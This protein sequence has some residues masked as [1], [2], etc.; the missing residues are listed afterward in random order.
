MWREWLRETEKTMLLTIFFFLNK[1]KLSKNRI[2]LSKLL[3][4]QLFLGELPLWLP[5]YHRQRGLGFGWGIIHI[6]CCIS[7]HLCILHIIFSFFFPF[8][9]FF[10]F[11]LLPTHRD[12]IQSYH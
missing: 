1:T 3:L 10:T 2:Q 6:M 9:L 4:L 12:R 8:T 5:E 7:F 11:S